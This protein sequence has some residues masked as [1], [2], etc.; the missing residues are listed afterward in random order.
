M[1]CAVRAAIL[2]RAQR[3]L[4][5]TSWPLK[6]TVRCPMQIAKLVAISSTIAIALIAQAS[7]SYA[8]SAPVSWPEAQ[9]KAAIAG[10]RAA[11]TDQATR[12]YLSRAHLTADQLPANFSAIF[13]RPEVRSIL[14]VCDCSLG[15]ISKEVSLDEFQFHPDSPLVQQRIKELTLPGGVCAP[16]GAPNNRSNGP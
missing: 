6:L 5:T 16:N 13:D 9:L 10:C 11:I 12:D 2:L 4:R 8:Q 15:I 14:G 3:V 1:T 7:L